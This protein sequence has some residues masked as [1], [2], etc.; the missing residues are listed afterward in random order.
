MSPM[1]ETPRDRWTD[2]EF[3]L[4]FG[5]EAQER[6][7]PVYLGRLQR[8]GWTDRIPTYL[9]WCE[10]CRI[11]P[12]GGFSVAH[13]AGYERRIECSECRT[14]YEHLLPSRRLKDMGLNPHHHPRLIAFLILLAILLAIA[15]R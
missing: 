1:P 3:I 9:V 11:R 12:N 15:S 5:K 10:R 7:R 8:P 14:R 2:A 6:G 4:A 13:E